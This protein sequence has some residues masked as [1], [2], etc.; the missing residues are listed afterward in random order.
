MTA[1]GLAELA[2]E[3]AQ[4]LSSAELFALAGQVAAREARPPETHSTPDLP[5]N[6]AFDCEG[7]VADLVERLHV[8]AGIDPDLVGAYLMTLLRAAG[9]TDAEEIVALATGWR[10]RSAEE[11]E[12][13]VA[14]AML[15]EGF[16]PAQIEGAMKKEMLS[17]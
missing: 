5:T 17:C 15:A 16:T 2:E 10:P 3:A 13:A 6:L 4:R 11:R 12:V 1:L 7:T 8:R 9:V 14:K